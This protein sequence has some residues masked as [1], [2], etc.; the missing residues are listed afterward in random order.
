MKGFQFAN[1][2][3]SA[4]IRIELAALN[5]STAQSTI[6]PG[7]L[8]RLHNRTAMVCNRVHLYTYNLFLGLLR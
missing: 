5:A 2:A 6:R 4:C 3:Q 8:G 1:L 7:V